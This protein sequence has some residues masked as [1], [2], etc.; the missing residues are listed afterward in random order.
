M[1]IAKLEI[2]LILA[3]ILL[4]FEYDLVDDKGK[5][6][7]ALPKPD[8]NDIQQVGPPSSVSADRAHSHLDTRRVP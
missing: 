2:K 4:G 7:K 5:Y 8:R 1:K 3:M 6:P